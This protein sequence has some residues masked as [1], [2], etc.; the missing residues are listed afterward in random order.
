MNQPFCKHCIKYEYA[1]KDHVVLL[2]HVKAQK[3]IDLC[4]CTTLNVSHTYNS[5][6]GAH[7]I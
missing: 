5:L 6:T 3:N 2:T 1:I 7:G 4:T